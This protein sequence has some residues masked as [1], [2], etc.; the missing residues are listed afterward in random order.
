MKLYVYELSCKASA[1][2]LS[3]IGQKLLRFSLCQDFG[4]LEYEICLSGFGKPYIKGNPINFNISHC[5]KS[6]CLLIG[7]DECGVDIEYYGRYKEKIAAKIC[8][9]NELVMLAGCVTASDKDRLFTQIWTKKEAC[10]KLDGRGFAIGFKNINT[11]EIQNIKTFDR[12]RYCV[13]S[14]SKIL[15]EKMTVLTRLS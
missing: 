3:L 5:E 1:K 6:V 12:D 2:E 4:I 9:E 8:C 7:E 14:A 13:S 15:P 10:S 11:L